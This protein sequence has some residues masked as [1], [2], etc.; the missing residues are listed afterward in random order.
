MKTE[1]KL[2]IYKLKVN[3]MYFDA[4]EC[5]PNGFRTCVNTIGRPPY[6][7]CFAINV[8]ILRGGRY[9]LVKNKN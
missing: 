6:G 3:A 1:Q 5:L 7:Y 4:Y 2:L 9:I 8:G